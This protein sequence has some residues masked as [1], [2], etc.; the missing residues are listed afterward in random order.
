M[1]YKPRCKTHIE[2]VA[3]RPPRPLPITDPDEVRSALRDVEARDRRVLELR[4]GL[5]GVRPHSRAEIGRLLGIS[6]E[7]VRQLEGRALDR[8]S[9]H[10]G[11]PPGTAEV[12]AAHVSQRKDR[13][14]ATPSRHSFLRSWTLVLLWLRPAHVYELRA[15][16]RELGLPAATYRMLQT[17]ERDG[18]LHSHWA[19]GRGAGP[20]R[21]VYSLTP[22]GVE[23]LRLDARALQNMAETLEL[24]L[25]GDELRPPTEAAEEPT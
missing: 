18:F 23:Q 12:P 3:S 14:A 19:P 13:G 24:L 22:R 21:R 20:N 11:A 15:R 16:L 10:A 5:E 25:A 6:R 9:A 4:Y 8:L 7:R 17:L 1:L 2:L